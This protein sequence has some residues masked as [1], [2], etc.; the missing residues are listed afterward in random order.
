MYKLGSK[1]GR[2]MKK[3]LVTPEDIHSFDNSAVNTTVKSW[4]KS[5][6][7]EL[8][9]Q[10]RDYLILQILIEVA[11]SPEPL[12]ALHVS[13]VMSTTRLSPSKSD[14][15]VKY[16]CEVFGHKTQQFQA[17]AK[18]YCKKN[19]DTG[20]VFLTR[21]SKQFK[22]GYFSSVVKKYFG[23]LNEPKKVNSTSFRKSATTYSFLSKG[24]NEANVM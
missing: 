8:Q 17:Y 7:T 23:H 21:N 4:L 15:E 13:K 19:S 20:F 6:Y 10:V 1:K 3:N 22:T 16:M 14:K 24:T 18:K 9:N 12:S 11:N 5:T 2:K